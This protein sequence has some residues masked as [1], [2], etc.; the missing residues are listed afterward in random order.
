MSDNNQ[1]QQDKIE[2]WLIPVS[3]IIIVFI[4]IIFPSCLSY[5]TNKFE[6]NIRNPGDT[7]FGTFGDTFG[8]LNTLFSGLAFATLIITLFLQRRELELQRKAVND[9]QIEIEKSNDIAEQQILITQQQADLLEK[10]IKEAQVQNFFNILFPLLNRKKTYYEDADDLPDGLKSGYIVRG[11]SESTFKSIHL[12]IS[13]IY[14]DFLSSHGN[15]FLPK[16]QILKILDEM[17]DQSTSLITPYSYMKYTKYIEHFSYV[18]SFIENFKGIDNKDR[19]IAMSIFLSEFTKRELVVISSFTIRD[20]LLMEKVVKHK[21]F[22]SFI[23]ADPEKKS[24]FYL[25]FSE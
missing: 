20:D 23:D 21:V 22:K 17:I 9:Q 11:K 6:W 7:N 16:D 12:G 18:I 19:D 2:K 13:K 25:L 15:D 10:Q 1:N 8:V 5:L 4:W 14:R 24:I 3:I